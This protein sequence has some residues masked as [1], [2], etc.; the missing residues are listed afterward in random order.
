MEQKLEAEVQRRESSERMVESLHT[1]IRARMTEIE[2]QVCACGC[3][4][5]TQIEML[6]FRCTHNGMAPRMCKVQIQKLN[7]QALPLCYSRTCSPMHTGDIGAVDNRG[8]GI[9]GYRN[10]TA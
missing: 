4:C 5:K 7:P 2:T 10:K 1:Q 6:K 3:M 9:E 8:V